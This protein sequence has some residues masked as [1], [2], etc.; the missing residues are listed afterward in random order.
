MSMS[1]S[2][3]GGGT[4]RPR[5]RNWH[6]VDH[7][8]QGKQYI[9]FDEEV[10]SWDPKTSLNQDSDDERRRPISHDRTRDSRLSL[11]PR[12]GQDSTLS[13]DANALKRKPNKFSQGAVSIK[14]RRV[15]EMSNERHERGTQMNRIQTDGPLGRQMPHSRPSASLPPPP[16]YRPGVDNPAVVSAQSNYGEDKPRESGRYDRK[17]GGTHVTRPDMMGPGDAWG[18]FGMGNWNAHN[19]GPV[20]GPGNMFASFPQMGSGGFLGMGQQFHVPQ[21]FG[22]RPSA[23]VGFGGA[24]FH[25]G[26]GGLAFP[27][28]GPNHGPMMGWH[29]FPDGNESHRPLSGFMD[30]SWEGPGRYLDDRQR[31]GH[32]EWDQFSQ[33]LSRGGWEGAPEP[34]PVQ[35]QSH[36]VDGKFDSNLHHSN[37][38]GVYPSASKDEDPHLDMDAEKIQLVNDQ[39]Q[40]LSLASPVHSTEPPRKADSKGSKRSQ[41][42]LQKILLHANVCAELVDADLYNEYLKLIPPSEATKKEAHNKMDVSAIF[43]DEDLE[44]EVW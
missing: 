19:Q 22:P 40:E 1:V 44:F 43:L 4:R 10:R 32:P 25:M 15:D 11:S 7:M 24:R 37:R 2:S 12:G 27:G 14:A 26:D 18:N 9:A 20:P 39:A 3:S 8:D 5:E 16:P 17:G 29:R 13:K 38:E 6:V 35:A 42:R 36:A 33:G 23:D 31:F 41:A 28:H 30:A 34:W 21:M